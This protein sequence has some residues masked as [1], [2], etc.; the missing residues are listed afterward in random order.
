MIFPN[1]TCSKEAIELDTAK[2]TRGTTLTKKVQENI[3]QRLYKFHKSGSNNSYNASN[4]DSQ[5]KNKIPE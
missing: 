1:L 4:S 3:S 5:N 2:N